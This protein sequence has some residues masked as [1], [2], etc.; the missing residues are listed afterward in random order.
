MVLFNAAS[1]QNWHTSTCRESQSLAGCMSGS[2]QHHDPQHLAAHRDMA[3]WV[4]MPLHFAP[5]AQGTVVSSAS[6]SILI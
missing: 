2:A 5:Y 1:Q 3:V 4:P 6:M